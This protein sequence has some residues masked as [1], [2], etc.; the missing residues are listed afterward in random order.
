MDV[1][2]VPCRPAAAEAAL[3]AQTNHRILARAL[4]GTMLREPRRARDAFGMV[5][6]ASVLWSRFLRFDAG[7]PR[8][9]D[10]DRFVISAARFAPLLRALLVLSGDETLGDDDTTSL[11]GLGFGQHPGVEMAI[12]P[13][14]QSIATATG[15]AIA[16]RMLAARFGH[17]L[18]DHRS[19]VLACE[20]DLSAGVALEAAALA[21][22]MRLDRLTVLFELD[23]HGRS[24]PEAEM[25]RDPMARFAACGW[26]VR[27]VD[28]ADP[29]AVA[30]AIASATRGR[31]PTLIAC[32]AAPRE[33]YAD[34][35]S[36][37]G[38]ECDGAEPT[39]TGSRSAASGAR[40]W[41]DVGRRGQSAR[42]AWLKRLARHRH[43]AEFERVTA[44][45]LPPGW[46]RSWRE[47]WS[48]GASQR[49]AAEHDV[50]GARRGLDALLAL[51]PEFV[52]LSCEPGLPRMPR[53]GAVERSL[54]LGTQEHGMASLLN[55]IALHGGLLAC[56]SAS[57]IAIDR[58][59]P[60]L[61]LAALM[62]RQ[63]IHL[64][65]H[66][67]L[68]LG[69]DGAAWQPVEQLASLR[70]MPNVAV[71]RPADGAEM[72]ECWQL[73][74]HRGEGPSLIAFSP[75]VPP[76]LRDVLRASPGAA[77]PP[78]GSACAR[79]GYVLVDTPDGQPRDVTLI[80]TGPEVGIAIDASRLLA[81]RAIRA[82]V[83]SLP[84][85]ELFAQ[86]PASYR[87]AILGPAP[88][89]GIEAA[90]GFGWERWLGRAGMFIGIDEF[91]ISAPADEIYRQF[92]ITPEAVCERVRRRLGRRDDTLPL[93]RRPWPGD[94]QQP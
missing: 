7:D 72:M 92:G 77:I 69:E 64:L 89:V 1:D 70:A 63:V 80:A 27:R 19:W 54:F 32:V 58:M 57:F 3:D 75:R 18:V 78:I 60:A 74:L 76:D 4:H 52:S 71:F 14:G 49:A 87:E 85:W 15:M 66:D 34:A 62:G 28:A 53:L 83:V 30:L 8:W 5:E 21:G 2:L 68:A 38:P 35:D 84:C 33:P 25:P 42:R 9:A 81:Y 47:A 26:S 36:A 24:T 55:G 11:H 45:R 43:A 91:G 94:H 73:A 10:R 17:S 88:R 23:A 82:A 93:D 61:R 6:A 51:L 40:A 67:G 50:S 20:T 29:E 59:R 90:S 37:G 86:Q 39:D 31:K 13:A 65:T 44:G 56:G 48:D 16:E 22:Q 41:R 46:R 79:G 12:G